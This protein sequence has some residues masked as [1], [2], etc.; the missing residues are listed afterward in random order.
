MQA[1]FS[2]TDEKLLEYIRMYEELRERYRRGLPS[3]CG[4]SGNGYVHDLEALTG[5]IRSGIELKDI[6]YTFSNPHCFIMLLSSYNRYV[7]GEKN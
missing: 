6:T 2:S 5:L 3:D 4:Y 1:T 7:K